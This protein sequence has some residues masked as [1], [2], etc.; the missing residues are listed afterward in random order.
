MG[1]FSNVFFFFFL[2]FLTSF[3]AWKNCVYCFNPTDFHN[4]EF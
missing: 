1:L 3:L 2:G 4:T